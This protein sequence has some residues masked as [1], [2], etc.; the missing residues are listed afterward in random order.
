MIR[1][2]DLVR[3]LGDHGLA[4]WVLIE[5]DQHVALADDKLR[6]AERWLRWQLTVHHD[7]P[8]GRGSA[9]VAVDAA[10][11]DADAVVRQ[12]VTLAR[13]SIGTAWMT[14]P[15]SAP[16]R[17]V[18]ADPVLSAGD[19]L[20]S[21]AELVRIPAP[22]P[23][24]G[25]AARASLL[26][27]RVNVVSRLGLRADWAATHLR[28]DA[29]VSRGERSLAIT[30]EARRREDLG[31]AA[32]VRAAADDLALLADANAPTPG[33]CS[34][35]LR[36]DALLHDGLGLWSAFVSQADAVIE[37]Q[38]LTRYRERAPIVPGADHVP[39]PL[40]I[41]S[42]GALD[43]GVR[44]APLGDDGDAVRRFQ[45][46]ERGIAAGLGLSPREGS[47]R[48]RDP[49]GGIRN[50]DVKPGTWTGT[51][52]ATGSRVIEVRRLR[53]LSIDPYTGDAALEILLATEHA[54]GARREISGGSLRLDAIEALAR[55]RRSATTLVRGA[56]SGPESVLITGGELL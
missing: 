56:Y 41:A 8:T 14:R 37:R 40:S 34:I 12:A 18:L 54:N 15:T 50:L 10:D 17:V 36:S 5:R 45:L 26:R 21:A 9:H 42:N 38:G 30:R 11:G 48:G 16:A 46:V 7:A 24:V 47:L 13:A 6:R 2:R 51:I 55:A 32:A 28:V 53:G 35:V 27:E 20:D 23:G 3:A 39:E 43:F 33:P 31:L 44:S 49:N 25:V 19:L 22:L 4:D 52:D 1:R 29:L